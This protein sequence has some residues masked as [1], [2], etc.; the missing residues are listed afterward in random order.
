MLCT[1]FCIFDVWYSCF[2]SFPRIILILI[3]IFSLTMIFQRMIWIWMI[4]FYATSTDGTSQ[5][6]RDD[7]VTSGRDTWGAHLLFFQVLINVL[8]RLK[9]LLLIS[10]WSIII[11][12]VVFTLIFVLNITSIPT[13]MHLLTALLIIVYNLFHQ[14]L[15]TCFAA[16]WSFTSWHWKVTRMFWILSWSL[17]LHNL[18]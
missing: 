7:G 9:K 1:G 12:Q 14:T 8:L 13:N 3:A 11:N 2:G 18:L 16:L 6:M 17:W 5:L 4:I 10:L 15:Y